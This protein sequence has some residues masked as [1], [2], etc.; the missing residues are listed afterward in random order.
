MSRRSRR[1]GKSPGVASSAGKRQ[2]N[3][4]QLKNPLIKTTGI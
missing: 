2:V 3:Y 4:K 1:G